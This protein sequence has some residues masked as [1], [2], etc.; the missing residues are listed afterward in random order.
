[1]A[2]GNMGKKYSWMTAAAAGPAGGLAAGAG[3][4]RGSTAVSRTASGTVPLAQQEDAGLRSKEFWKKLGEWREGKDIQIRD[5][6][7]VLE[8]DGVEKKTLA[9][10]YARLSSAE[11]ERQVEENSAASASTP[12]PSISK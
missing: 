7:T 8:R 11:K 4:G 6:I 5:F 10:C 2:L 12:R 3:I 9:K 1:M